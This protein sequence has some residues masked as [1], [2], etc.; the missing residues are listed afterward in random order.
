[1]SPL[2]KDELP[3]LLWLYAMGIVLFWV[4][5]TSEGTAKT[6]ALIDRSVP[7]V[8]KLVNLTR[9]RLLRSAI[10]DVKLLLT[11]VKQ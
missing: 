1:M 3:E 4:H 10:E 7:L 8:G 5:D 2:V 6:Y 11:E 9:Y